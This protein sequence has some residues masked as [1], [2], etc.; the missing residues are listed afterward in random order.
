MKIRIKAN[1]KIQNKPRR[2]GKWRSQWSAKIRP[3]EDAAQLVG[4][5]KIQVCQCSMQFIAETNSVF[6]PL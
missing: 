2:N 6:Q 1:F 5:M 3:S 4:L